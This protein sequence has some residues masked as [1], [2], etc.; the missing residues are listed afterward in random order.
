MRSSWRSAASLW[1]LA[2]LF[3]TALA[4][5]A[6][7]ASPLFDVPKLDDITI[8]GKAED[9]GERGFRV[10]ILA[11]AFGK[12]PDP[13][14][15]SAKLRLGW[16]EKGLLALV[17]VTDD[18]FLEPEAKPEELWKGDSIEF[19][20]ANER[21]GSESYQVVI[22]PGC[23]PNSPEIRTNISDYRKNKA[24]KLAVEVA[25]TKGEHSFVLEALLPWKNLGIE[26]ADGKELGFQFYANDSDKPGERTQLL[27]YPVPEA[28]T[29]SNRMYRIRLSAKPSAPVQVAAFGGY[30]ADGKAVVSVA[31]VP[32]LKGKK[33]KVKEDDKKVGEEKLQSEGGAATAKIV[34]KSKDTPYGPLTVLLED[35]VLTTIALP[36]PPQKK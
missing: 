11:D 30:D 7:P 16:N 27:W 21:G 13:K 34:L 31:A 36:Q 35:E 14:N 5:T 19:F 8:D 1:P 20:V 22:A 32:E 18:V 10:D 4:R 12:V 23:D 33:V 28:H 24:E 26:P 2:F 9:W 17:S 6:E 15:Y 25:R 3:L 29:D